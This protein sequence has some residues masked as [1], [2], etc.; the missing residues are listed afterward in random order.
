MISGLLTIV[1]SLLEAAL[2][3]QAAWDASVL[4]LVAIAMM[5]SFAGTLTLAGFEWIHANTTRKF[6]KNLRWAN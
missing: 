5:C 1:S 6:F 3:A 4:A 2:S